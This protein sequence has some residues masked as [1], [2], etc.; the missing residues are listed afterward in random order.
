MKAAVLAYGVALALLLA[1]RRLGLER[2]G[3]A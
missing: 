2:R 3:A 1:A